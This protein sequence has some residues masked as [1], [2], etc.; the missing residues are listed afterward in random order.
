MRIGATRSLWEG[1]R[2]AYGSRGGGGSSVAELPPFGLLRSWTSALRRSKKKFAK[3][4]ALQQLA[5]K[6]VQSI[7]S[8]WCLA[9]S[10]D[11]V[12]HP[13]S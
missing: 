7:T 3:N 2:R 12:G 5:V 10:S 1:V 13:P 8:N 9:S 6:L 4:G 11:Q